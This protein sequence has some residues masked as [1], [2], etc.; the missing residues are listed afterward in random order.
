MDTECSYV[1]TETRTRTRN[2]V[3]DFQTR[4]PGFGRTAPGLET[5]ATMG[6]SPED[7]YL[8]KRLWE[9]KDYRATCLCKMFFDK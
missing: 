1:H 3:L 6:L 8:I 7:R 2:P 5:L 4:K 9:S